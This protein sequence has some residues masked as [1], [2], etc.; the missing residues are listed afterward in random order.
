MTGDAD[1]Q[2][3]D[4]ITLLSGLP[5]ADRQALAARCSWRPYST[6]E[7]ILS[8]DQPSRDVLFIAQGRVRVVTYA[9]S[10]REVAF[11]VLE[12]GSHVGELSA[13]D[14]A[15]RSASV[16]A[17]EPCRVA[18][19]P[20]AAFQDLLLR[21]PALSLELLKGLA[22][23][24]RRSDERIAELSVLGAVPRVY[25]ELRRLARPQGKG[26]VIAPLPTQ[27]ALAAHVGATRETVAR[28]LGQLAK[29]GIAARRGRELVIRD[30]SLLEALGEPEA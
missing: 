17:L 18:A 3:L 26:A 20:P 15:P 4:G 14:G 1:R 19:L 16:E 22:R 10:G 21:H 6:G 13:L 2:G 7:L 30:L 23:I 12:A 25:R 27:E 5:P 29:A 9:A 11:A 28:A 24:V 8:P